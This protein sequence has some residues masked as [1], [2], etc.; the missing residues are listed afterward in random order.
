MC[1]FRKK[2]FLR[3]FTLFA[4]ITLMCA[5]AH[6]VLDMEEDYL[7]AKPEGMPDLDASTAFMSKYIWRGQNLVDAPVMQF[8]VNL[9]KYGFTLD[10]WGNYSM[11]RDKAN[12]SYQELTELDYTASYEFSVGEMM[13]YMGVEDAE[14]LDPWS[15]SMGYT[16]YT[17]PNMDLDEKGATSHEVF[18][19]TSYDI[20]LQPFFTWYWDVEAGHGSYLQFGGGHTFDL[21]NDIT[22]DIGAAFGYNYEQWTDKH[23]WSDM[24]LSLDVTI[25]FFNHFYLVP[26]VSYSV[27]LDR[28]TYNDA[29]ENEFFGG[30]TL[31]FSY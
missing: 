30:V 11:S 4:G 9:S 12:G 16:F 13:G 18:V 14:A 10:L 22:A 2:I 25:P 7:P 8:D 6:A 27:I 28:D 3:A 17:F 29:Q 20:L 23:G 31:G 1:S 21:G 24:L 5:S 15:I 19:G 26:N